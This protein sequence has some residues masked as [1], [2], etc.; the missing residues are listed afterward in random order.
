MKAEEAHWGDVGYEMGGLIDS[1]G[2]EESV[3]PHHVDPVKKEFTSYDPLRKYLSEIQRFELLSREEEKGLAI[4]VREKGDE[5]ATFRLITSNL[6]LVVKIALGFQRHNSS[7]VLDLIQEGNLGLIHALKKFDPERGTRFSYYAAYWIR[8]YIL[9][10]IMEN[11]KLVKIGT[12]QHQRKLFYN[13]NKE[14][15]K[16]LSLGLAPEPEILAQR[17]DVTK[18]EVIEMAERLEGADVP[19]DFSALE[20]ADAAHPVAEGDICMKLSEKQRKEMM[21]EKLEKFRRTLSKKEG[22]IFDHRIMAEEPLTL[23]EI[24]EKY[25]I[26]RERVRQRQ[27]S[28]VLKLK[29]WLEEE[30]PGFQ[31]RYIDYLS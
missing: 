11:R 14:K 31:E 27:K 7:K 19:F 25:R 10:F 13:L 21:K 18:E 15:Q 24:G 30:I 26:S 2:K 5:R 12:T 8:A 20:G 6:R 1:V 4:R 29:K 23:R 28:I 16:I 17:L 22:F 9:R 3:E